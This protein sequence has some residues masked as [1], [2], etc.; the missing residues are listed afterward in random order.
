MIPKQL[1]SL[2]GQERWLSDSQYEL[3]QHRSAGD[4]LSILW[5]STA[6]DNHWEAQLMPLDIFKAFERNRYE[7]GQTDL[8]T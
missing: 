4:L 7:D 5:V 3:W 2:V 8:A 6:L 1:L